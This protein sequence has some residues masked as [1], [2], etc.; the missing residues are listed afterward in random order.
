MAQN[1]IYLVREASDGTFEEIANSPFRYDAASA[2]DQPDKANNTFHINTKL[3]VDELEV[4]GDT[5][6]IHTDSNTTEQLSVTNDGTGPAA[7]I[8][9]IGAE[10]LIDIQ[11]D[12]V[13][14]LYIA[15]GGN[16]GIGTTNPVAPLHVVGNSIFADP[17][18]IGSYLIIGHPS[19]GGAQSVQIRMY[20]SNDVLNMNLIGGASY[21]FLNGNV[22][23]GPLGASSVA[24]DMLHISTPE[25][26]CG[27]TL[28][29]ETKQA[30]LTANNEG[31]L[32]L[33][34]GNG[35]SAP[36]S[37]MVFS[38]N[39]SEAMRIR[40]NGNVGIG[41]TSPYAKL[42]IGDDSADPSIY[43]GKTNDT[44]NLQLKYDITND[45]GIVEAWDANASSGVSTT[46]A[47]NPS[48][49]NVGIGTSSPTSKLHL[50]IDSGT[51]GDSAINFTAQDQA[52][53]EWEEAFKH[54]IRARMA[55]NNDLNKNFLAFDIC[56]GA[57]GATGSPVG[58][59][60]QNVLVLNGTGNVGIG[61]S[62][63]S[64]TLD[65][66][67]PNDVGTFF[68]AMND[69][70]AGADFK[71]VGNSDPYNHFLFHNGNVGIGTSSPS[72][73]LEVA[74]ET[75][76]EIRITDTDPNSAAAGTF[77]AED[78]GVTLGTYSDHPLYL[79]ANNTTH[80]TI[81]N[82]GDVGI[83]TTTPSAILEVSR[84]DQSETEPAL[85]VIRGDTGIDHRPTAPI[86]NV[87][88]GSAGGTEVFRVRGDG[89]VGIGTTSPVA[90]L[91]VVGNS[92]FADP[93]G[94]GSS[95]IIGH[96]STG[97]AQSAQI[98]MYD[99]ND[100]LNMNLIGGASYEFLNGNVGIG[101]TNPV[102]QLEIGDSTSWFSGNQLAFGDG[103]T[104]AALNV[105]TDYDGIAGNNYVRLMSTSGIMFAPGVGVGASSGANAMV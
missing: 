45:Y 46:L 73:L 6:V 1:D 7:I 44:N 15:D 75:N 71:R 26:N 89:N 34:A 65:V 33:F 95:L 103:T 36:D 90:P 101:A 67:G 5:T 63:P 60:A 14:A 12:G 16:V 32:L 17:D 76:P 92:I 88:N 20:D 23:I 104:G 27:L 24:G 56:S 52:S 84:L 50:S 40:N 81:T 22:G 39:D 93:D 47:L 72:A 78:G 53:P 38:V 49:G 70:A 98:R 97:G 48:G 99:S 55:S 59:Q 11:D 74:G 83:G 100:V 66:V 86:F 64:A 25:L 31:T 79:A 51:G 102:N 80:M 3:R 82:A 96:P 43:I 35:G 68:S 4:N 42:H 37:K 87:F 28:H 85:K 61:T 54:S 57:S 21:E 105:T 94:I 10:P 19:T 30:K 8:N 77:R 2:T 13:S 41:A 91:H 29:A 9:Q 58:T 69:G 62:S 18:G